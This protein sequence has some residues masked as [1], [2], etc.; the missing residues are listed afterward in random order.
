MRNIATTKDVQGTQ[1]DGLVTIIVRPGFILKHPVMPNVD[2]DEH[3]LVITKDNVYNEKGESP[4][5]DGELPEK[6][7]Y[8]MM[9]VR[10]SENTMPWIKALKIPHWSGVQNIKIQAKSSVLNRLP[11]EWVTDKM[12]K[13]GGLPTINTPDGLIQ[14]SWDDVQDL[15]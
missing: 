15:T 8:V 14:D 12:V 6:G 4:S 11:G 1:N 7:E 9:L 2:E 5:W 3:V 13:F 10:G